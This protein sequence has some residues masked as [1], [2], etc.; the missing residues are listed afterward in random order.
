MKLDW[1]EAWWESEEAQEW[2][3][4]MAEEQRERNAQGNYEDE[5]ERT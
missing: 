4:R 5:A 1:D 3:D 2:L